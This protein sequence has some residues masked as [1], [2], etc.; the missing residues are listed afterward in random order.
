MYRW[1]N[2]RSGQQRLQAEGRD[3]QEY[4]EFQ[5]RIIVVDLA[6]IDGQTE[7]FEGRSWLES[8]VRDRLPVGWDLE[9]QPDRTK[10][11][12]NPIALMQFADEN[13][14]LLLRTHRTRNWLP[15][16][17]FRALTCEGCTKVGVGWDG[18][19]KQKMQ[20]TF[21]LQPLGIADLSEI[22]KKK[23]VAEQ[24][25]KSLTEH[26][27]IRMRKDSRIAR[28]NWAASELTQEQ[29]QYA[30]E[31]AY[32]SYILFDKLRTLP[33]P[34][35]ED[36]DGYATVNQ[37]VLE[38]QPGWEEQGIVRRHDGLW[39][40]MCE[41]GPMTVPL[42]VKRH[43]E[44]QKHKKKLEQKQ[45]GGPG[46]GLSEDLPEEY[47]MQGIV[48]GD[49]FND[50]RIG[51]YKCQV[52][53]AGP[54][55]ALQTVE[56]HLKSKKHIKNTTT[57]P[58]STTTGEDA[59]MESFEDH[60]W[61]FPDYVT[62]DESVL[63]CTLCGAKA[64]TVM[65]MYM[66]LGGDKHAKKCR[67]SGQE[68]VLHIKERGQLEFVVTGRPVVRSGF[69]RP[70][71]GDRVAAAAAAASQPSEAASSSRAP[72]SKSR[73][74]PD[75]WQ[76]ETDPSSGYAYYY[77]ISLKISQWE[78]PEEPPPLPPGW[79]RVWDEGAMRHYYAD[80]ETQ[81]SQWDPPPAYEH[82][83]WKRLV[84]PMGRAYWKC[85]SQAISFYEDAEGWQRLV[86]QQE[87][88]YWSNQ[89]LGIRFFEEPPPQGQ[90]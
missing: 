47:I 80:V 88:I 63:T 74:L 49:G 36:A 19:D 57:A 21:N 86:D 32:F 9:W 10:D 5:G 22:A 2:D 59:K 66:H 8:R 17:V 7:E 41:K 13:V 60:L 77:N 71:P 38:L 76:E 26:F 46:S 43:M 4:D 25:L 50:I 62:L 48:A 78:R 67:T 3:R 87:C 40:A 6:T 64:L 31:D 56:A 85:A 34:V 83:G 70:K 90:L 28:S 29:I 53:D 58:E 42:V 82:G 79:D 81:R 24:G 61:N 54:F 35:I 84:D 30:A 68:E 69:K 65:A 20:S 55:N 89:E 27:G 75:G 39:C 72:Q 15:G 52:C 45:G 37:G 16:T 14:A 23:G 33:D 44:A 73:P 12:D 51:E 1:L 18:P 11:S